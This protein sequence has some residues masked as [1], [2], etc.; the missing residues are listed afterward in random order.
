MNNHDT[1]IGAFFESAYRTGGRKSTILTGPGA[2]SEL[3]RF[4]EDIAPDRVLFIA[5]KQASRFHRPRVEQALSTNPPVEWFELSGGDDAKTLATLDLVLSW[6]HSRATR[7]SLVV[8]FG[9]TA[10]ANV[11][12]L[13]ASL[14]Y[15]GI[16]FG[17]VP[18]TYLG[19]ADGTIGLKQSINGTWAKNVIGVFSQPDFTLND[20]DFCSSQ[21]EDDLRDGLVET[22]KAAVAFEPDLLPF[23]TASV[24]AL[25]PGRDPHLLARLVHESARIKSA[26]LGSDPHEDRELYALE[27]G[28]TVAHALEKA[29]HGA[30]HHGRAVA[31][32]LLAETHY[33]RRLGLLEDD[34]LIA[35]LHTVLVE[36]LEHPDTLPEGADVD[37]LLS[38]IEL[39]GHR[40]KLGPRFVLLQAPGRT[41]EPS[42]YRPNELRTVLNAMVTR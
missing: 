17:H 42:T 23:F 41:V 8:S 2:V 37:T 33:A 40:T 15:R 39:D 5:D 29:T 14:I 26:R 32:G 25:L 31:I 12:G 1:R 10:V 6:L 9:G 36:V 21:S 18:T 28:H 24:R 13:A 30:V 38:H 11:T 16:R 22:Y 4:V 34:A 35:D 27:I 3:N 7:D 19:Q 20:V